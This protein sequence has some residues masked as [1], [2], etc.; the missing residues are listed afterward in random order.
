MGE[1]A[2]KRASYADVLA[3][4][5]HMVAEVIDGE[6]HLQPRP[7]MPHARAAS[8]MSG[9]LGE[10]FDRGRGGPG[11]W[12]ILFEPE[13]HLGPEPD[14]LVPD[15]AS[16]RRE[17]LPE[18]PDSAFVTIAP[19]W[20]CEIVSPSTAR[21]D[22]GPKRRIYAREGVAWLWLVDPSAKTLEIYRLHA[23]QWVEVATFD[24]ESV[25]RAQ[26]FDAV[27]LELAALWE[28]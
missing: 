25:V 27:E 7:A 20:V 12:I 22:R 19:D 5:E 17:R 16:W 13:L 11:G 15:L 14:I 1:P 9:V 4:P 24:G 26:P 21:R 18:V 2:L 10:P 6:L 23:G 28:R 3:A 8:R